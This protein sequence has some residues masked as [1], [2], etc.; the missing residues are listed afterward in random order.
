MQAN[1][2]A[3]PTLF[4]VSSGMLQSH[5]KYH[6]NYRAWLLLFF[7]K[8]VCMYVSLFSNLQTDRRAFGF[9]PLIFTAV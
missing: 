2:V 6:H 8:Y 3:H 7:N 5:L 4:K 9:R 1:R